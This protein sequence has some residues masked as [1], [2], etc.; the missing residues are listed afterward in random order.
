[1]A[2][3]TSSSDAVRATLAVVALGVTARL[4]DCLRSLE[5]HESTCAFDIV[6][7]VNAESPDAP[8]E[9]S[10]LETEHPR[11]RFVP[12]PVNL[13]WA[14]GL[15]LA[16][17]YAAGEYLVQVQDDMVVTPG[18][19]DALVTAADAH[20]DIGAFGSLQVDEQGSARRFNAGFAEPPAEVRRWNDTDTTV[21][22]TPAEV[23]RF[24]WVTS[25]GMLARLSAWDDVGGPDPRLFP[26]NHV[27]KDYCSHLRAHGWAVALVP[28]ANLVH[29]GNQ[30]APG[31]MRAFLSEWHA[32]RLAQRWG[33]VLKQLPGS[34]ARPLPHDCTRGRHERLEHEV[35]IEASTLAVA[36]GR[37][38]QRR[39]VRQ[40]AA[41]ES[42]RART[43]KAE[44]EVVAMRSSLSWKLTSPLRRLRAIL[45][46]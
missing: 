44:A 17:R 46:R 20:H 4:G 31:L 1:M 19:L 7:V 2:S 29:Q 41:L 30:S 45:S 28:T 14:G 11:V 22:N 32:D 23:T 27:D 9:L 40:D 12:S 35:A 37:W 43:V 33:E 25:K 21:E 15:Q 13:G 36:V 6:C 8:L 42:A 10:T 38:T 18:W 24:G 16:R 5:S 26:L 34:E 3:P 39:R